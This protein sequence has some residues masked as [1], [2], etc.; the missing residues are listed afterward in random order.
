MKKIIKSIAV[1]TVISVVCTAVLVVANYFWKVEE[2]Q[3]V[4]AELLKTFRELAND[5]TAEF[6]E[7]E[8][9]GIEMNKDIKNVYKAT[10]GKNANILIVRA[11]GTAGN[12][13][14]VIMLTAI[15]TS[16]D[17]VIASKLLENNTTRD[18][19]ISFDKAKGLD[20]QTLQNT[21]FDVVTGATYTSN[22]MSYAV[23][24][25][26]EEYIANKDAILKAR[27]RSYELL[28]ITIT[29]EI[30]PEDMEVNTSVTILIEVV[31]TNTKK[32]NLKNFALSKDDVIVKRNGNKISISDIKKMT[33]SNEEKA[34]FS[35]TLSR[36]R[37]GKYDI[38]VNVAIKKNKAIGMLSFEI[39]D[40]PLELEVISRMFEGTTEVTLMDTN[41]ATGVKVYKN[42]LNNYIFAYEGLDYDYGESNI[43]IAFDGSGNIFI[44]DGEVTNSVSFN[45]TSYLN[46]F[47]GKN[48]SA[49]VGYTGT[50]NIDGIDVVSNATLSSNAINETVSRI[51]DFYESIGNI[52]DY[53]SGLGAIL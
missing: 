8:M 29:T 41:E 34:V 14:N 47:K 2:P 45:L 39:T 26:M 30:A 19:D 50:G 44:I 20:N 36:V 42:N 21:Q 37:A 32:A 6:V 9:S 49:F 13:G 33:S 35:L 4:S 23:K 27:V 1:L 51:C 24:L 48:A 38:D 46:N 15:N 5:E 31:S 22:A 3:G 52:N 7:L 43:Y 17:T 12:F 10:A 40:I 18:A 25:S 28:T 16:N 53:L 11:N